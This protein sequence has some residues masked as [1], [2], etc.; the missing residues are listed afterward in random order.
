MRPVPARRRRRA[1]RTGIEC[2]VICADAPCANA[3]R[4][5]HR[6]Q[7]DAAQLSPE[8]SLRIQAAG[9]GGGRKL[10]AE[11]LSPQIGWRGGFV[12]G[13]VQCGMFAQARG[14]AMST[15]KNSDKPLS[16]WTCAG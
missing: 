2:K 8:H 11:F 1:E 12:M 13:A 3:G 16:R 6:F 14:I 5:D 10:A 9:L 7:P 4:G 15:E